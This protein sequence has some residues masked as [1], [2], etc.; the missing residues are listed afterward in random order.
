MGQTVRNLSV[1]NLSSRA[2]FLVLGN[3]ARPLFQITGTMSRANSGDRPDPGDVLVLILSNGMGGGE[4]AAVIDQLKA[5]SRKVR[6]QNSFR[7]VASLAKLCAG[8]VLY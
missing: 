1:R 5:N 3:R 6:V 4:L 2:K 8:Q 7:A